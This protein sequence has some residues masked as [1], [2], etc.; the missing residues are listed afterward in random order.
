MFVIVGAA[1]IV[2]PVLFLVLTDYITVLI[3]KS[4]AILFVTTAVLWVFAIPKIL[5]AFRGVL[6]ESNITLFQQQTKQACSKCGEPYPKNFSV[7]IKT[8]TETDSKTYSNA[9]EEDV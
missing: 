1:V 3:F 5:S 6:V 7:S 9:T 4:I 2:L 8:H